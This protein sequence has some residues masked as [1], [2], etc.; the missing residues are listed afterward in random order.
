MSEALRLVLD[1]F[2]D[3]EKL[4]CRLFEKDDDFRLL[5][6]DYADALKAIEIWQQSIKTEA[7]QR[8]IEYQSLVGEL[9]QDIRQSL[10]KF[11]KK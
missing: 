10:E 7:P 11:A 2:S 4:I 1:A 3:A 8:V 9:Q 6:R 5:C